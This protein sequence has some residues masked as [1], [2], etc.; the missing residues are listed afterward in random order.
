M[1]VLIFIKTVIRLIVCLYIALARILF[2][3]KDKYAG[4]VYFETDI[5][6]N[7]LQ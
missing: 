4:V 6:L 3:I 5:L 2:K 1:I 7:K